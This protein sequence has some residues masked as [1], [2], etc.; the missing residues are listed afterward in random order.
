MLL[1]ITDGATTVQLSGTSP[2]VGCVYFPLPGDMQDLAA[3]VTEP[4]VVVLSGTVDSIRTVINTV[5][6]LLWS[7]KERYEAGVGPRIFVQYRPVDTDPLWRAELQM[8]ELKGADDKKL[9]NLSSVAEATITITITWQRG[10]VWEGPRFQA[11]L[12]NGNGSN[13][14][15][16][17]TVRLHDDGTAGH[18]NWVEIDSTEVK[19][20]LP[21]LVE[22]H[23]KNTTGAAR[24]FRNLY[25]ATN[26]YAPTL[27]HFVEGEARDTGFGSIG[28]SASRASRMG[29]SR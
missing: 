16:G 5:N 25:V 28:A 3:P 1:Q 9:R 19:G 7:A 14:T 26:P 17:L 22:I 10:G 15:A 4:V 23:L 20:D 29:L 12:S 6:Q 27:A 21:A 11:T 8:G 18:D 2:V 24:G 13:N